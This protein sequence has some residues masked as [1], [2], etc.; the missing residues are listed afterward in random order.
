MLDLKERYV[1]DKDGNR[2][3]VQLDI[4]AYE[5]LV[6]EVEA[7][8]AE[9]GAEAPRNGEAS[10]PPMAEPPVTPHP[11]LAGQTTPRYVGQRMQFKD[12]AQYFQ[13]EWVLLGDLETTPTPTIISGTL[14]WHSPSRDEIHEILMGLP[15]VKEAAIWY[16]SPPRDASDNTLLIL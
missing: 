5:K 7:A 6:A 16:F 11:P 15:M 9:T 12:M 10:S 14:L 13:G 1:M 8:R 3:A 2:V 4:Q